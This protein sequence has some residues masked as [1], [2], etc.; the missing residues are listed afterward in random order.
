MNT[1]PMV[2][3]ITMQ[4]CKRCTFDS[5]GLASESEGYPGSFAVS[6]NNA[7]ALYLL[8]LGFLS[9]HSTQKTYNTYG[10]DLLTTCITQ[11]RLTPTLGYKTYN[12]FSVELICR[13]KHHHF[14]R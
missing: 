12:T 14:T 9:R 2:N 10:V 13:Y 3:V 8:Y 7:V 11:G 5:P 1:S 6:G 4:R